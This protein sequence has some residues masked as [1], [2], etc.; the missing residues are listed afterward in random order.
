MQYVTSR[1]GTRIAY[2][3]SGQGPPLLLIH[4]MASDHQR[5]HDI[6]PRLA[7]HLAVYA[8]DRRGRGESGDGPDYDILREAEDVAAVVEA[9][10]EPAAVLGHSYGGLC[11]WR[12]G[13]QPRE[14]W[15]S[16][17]RASSTP[18]DTPTW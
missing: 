9:L 1:D 16:R 5:W 12:T 3:C 10:D 4:A 18:A 7:E 15:P 11:A 2:L 8:M 14:S 13:P 6:T 17:C